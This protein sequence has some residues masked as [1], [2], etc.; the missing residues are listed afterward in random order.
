[1]EGYQY[2]HTISYIIMPDLYLKGVGY[3]SSYVELF[4]D[5]GFIGL[6]IGGILTG[7]LIQ[8]FSKMMGSKSFYL[9]F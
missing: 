2:T 9:I 1:M 5:L 8:I 6:I 4:H 7:Y 3:G